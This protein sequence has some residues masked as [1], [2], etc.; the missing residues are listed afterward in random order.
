MSLHIERFENNFIENPSYALINYTDVYVKDQKKYLKLTMLDN[1]FTSGMS[2]IEL[3]KRDD[4]ISSR[5]FRLNIL[6]VF[7]RSFKDTTIEKFFNLCR[8]STVDAIFRGALFLLNASTAKN[9]YPIKSTLLEYIV[10]EIIS[11]KF[12]NDFKT[13]WLTI[14]EQIG[15][16]FDPDDFAEYFK[17]KD[18]CFLNERLKLLVH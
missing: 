3:S 16:C 10:H 17:L 2:Y 15:G 8:Q 1:A 9:Y 13:G 11:N 6:D 14:K 4:R 5:V 18:E 12:T 7:L